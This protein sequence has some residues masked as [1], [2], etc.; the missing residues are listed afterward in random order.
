M[1]LW[2][3]SDLFPRSPEI[4]ATVGLPCVLGVVFDAPP[5]DVAK[6]GVPITCGHCG[7]AL[8]DPAALRPIAG[9]GTGFRCAFCNAVVVLSGAQPTGGDFV[10]RAEKP[11]RGLGPIVVGVIDVSGSMADGALEA[12]RQSLSNTLADLVANAAETRFSLIT[13]SSR[14]VMHACSSDGA[15][16]ER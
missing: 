5:R 13:F 11:S 8:C 2:I 16:T 12:V 10:M 15:I 1:R 9:V 7:A 4:N 3:S 6:V 14:V